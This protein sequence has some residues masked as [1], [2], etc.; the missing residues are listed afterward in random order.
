[1]ARDCLSEFSQTACGVHVS[2]EAVTK[3]VLS[4]RRDDSAAICGRIYDRLCEHFAHDSVF[5]DIDA[6]PLGADFR[7]QIRKTISRADAFLAIVGPRW[8]GKRRAGTRIAD[9]SDWVRI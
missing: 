8:M 9:P 3:V 1:M 7:E 4:Y 2:G 6:I 5:M